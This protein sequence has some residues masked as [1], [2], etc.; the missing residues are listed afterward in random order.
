[1][2][3]DFFHGIESVLL[4]DQAPPIRVLK[5]SV[6]GIVGTAGKGPVNEPIVLTSSTGV[7]SRRVVADLLGEYHSDGFTLP[8]AIDGIFDQAGATIVAVNVCDPAVHRSTNTVRTTFGQTRHAPTPHPHHITTA[9]FGGGITVAR[10]VNSNGAYLPPGVTIDRVSGHTIDGTV[11]LTDYTDYQVEPS[12]ASVRVNFEDAV[13]DTYKR[14]TIEYSVGGGLEEGR[15]YF[16]DQEAGVLSVPVEGSR[17]AFGSSLEV[18]YTYVDPTKVTEGDIIGAVGA[19]DEATGIFALRTAPAKVELRPRILIAPRFTQAVT[20]GQKNPVVDELNTAAKTLG[21]R[22]VADAPNLDKVTA[23]EYAS[24]FSAPDDRV[25]IH[26]PDIVVRDPDGE[27]ARDTK[28]QPASARIAGLIAKND[29]TRGWWT[30]PSNQTIDGV[31]ALSKALTTGLSAADT[32]TNFLN[33]KG[34]T[35]TIIE[36][37]FR[38]WGN[39]QANMEFLS[40]H[41]TADIIAESVVQSHLW[42]VDRNIG[43]G[44]LDQIV[45]GVKAFLRRLE[46]LGAIVPNPSPDR[47][48]DVWA[49]PSLNTPESVADGDLFIDYR[50]NPAPNAEHITFRAHLT[51]DYTAE[52]FRQYAEAGQ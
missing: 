39:R 24:F 5:S 42:A 10:E 30:S 27:T 14:V 45:E 1:M 47:D 37:G 23:I 16:I 22:V 32:D 51:R 18:E 21:A 41:R 50:F 36:N 19:N 11:D 52:L 6:I 43:A 29:R 26:Y 4:N 17:I 9:V 31:L 38:L 8:E 20:P 3:T 46:G 7:T 48:N 44:L 25:Y 40:V 15:D 34:V 12:E 28:T 35:T 49:D 13:L 2:N 33:S